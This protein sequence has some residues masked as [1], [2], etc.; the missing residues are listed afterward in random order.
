L[1]FGSVIALYAQEDDIRCRWVTTKLDTFQLD[2]LSILPASL[3]IK[4][5]A[6]SNLT[7]NYDLNTGQV[8][9]I[10]EASVDSIEICYRVLPFDLAKR[11]YHRDPLRYDSLERYSDELYRFPTPFVRPREEIFKLEGL[12][13]SG[14]L[15]RGISAGNNQSAFVNSSLNLQIE[16]QLSDEISILANIS[17]QDVPFQPEG[18]TLQLQE[19]DRVFVQ[20]SHRL[21]S[22]TVGDVVLKHKENYFLKYYKNVQGG[23]LDAKY[24][25]GEKSKANTSVGFAVAK[26]KFASISV[27]PLEGVQGPYRL[28]GPNGERFIIILANSEKVYIDGKLMTRG[29]NY[30]YVIDYN[31]AEIIFNTNIQITQFTRIRIDFEY[32]EQN[33]TRTI[34]TGSHY[35][36]FK[37]LD[38]FFNI[39]RASDNPRNPII[40]LSD[41]DRLLLS[42]A[43][44]GL[45]LV[46]GVDSVGFRSDAVLYE[47][48]DTLTVEGVLYENIWVYSTNP[49]LAIYQVSFTEVR[50]NQGDYVR[51]NN[52]ING[53]VYAWQ[54][55]INGVS[56]GNF[57]ARRIVPTPTQQQLMTAGI[58]YNLSESDR[59]YLE[60]GIS[61]QDNNRF[62]DLSNADN[63]GQAFKV[64]YLNE[65]KALPFGKEL[66]WSSHLS[67]EHNTRFFRPIDRF[68]SIEFNRDWSIQ[69]DTNR[70]ADNIL[71]LEGGL[72]KNQ[73]NFAQY[74]FTYRKR[75][76]EADGWQQDLHLKKELGKFILSY[77]MF[78]LR[79]VQDSI[80]SDWKRF[81]AD[82]GYRIGG[83]QVGY[84]FMQD[85]NQVL[86]P[87]LDSVIQT[88][89]NFDQHQLYF[90]T[91]DT[92]KVKLSMDFSLRE[93]NQP[94]EGRLVRSLYSQ[95]A[96]LRLEARPNAN[97]QIALTMTYR[98]LENTLDSIPKNN[99]NNLMGRLDWNANFWEKHVRSELSF[100]TLT[101]RE[102]Q[103]EFVFLQVQT[104][105]GTH[106]WR[107]DNQDGVQDLEEF[108]LAINPDERQY[109]KVFVPTDKYIEA[110]INNFSYR[111]NWQSPRNWQTKKGWKGF[112]GKFSQI[113]SWTINKRFTD[114]S[115]LSR[116]IPFRGLQD[117]DVLSTR[118]VMRTTLFFD[119]SNPAFGWEGNFL[120]NR[121]KQLLSN[122]FEERLQ[123]EY[124]F[125]VRGNLSKSINL[126][127]TPEIEFLRN[128]SNVLLNR[129]Y[130]VEGYSF[131]PEIAFQPSPSF[132]LTGSYQLTKRTGTS[133]DIAPE[134]ATL[135][136]LKL[137][138][139]V[140]QVGKRNILL[141]VRWVQIQYN[142]ET[143]TPLSYE[144]LEALNPG[145]N[146]TWT[147]NWQQRLA[148]GL[149]L[150]LNY[151]GRKP[152]NTPTIHV[153]RIQ[154]TALF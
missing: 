113:L 11:R 153:G 33:Y 151:N 101:G 48:R 38:F 152:P 61:S 126:S 144:M 18:N 16:G 13:K 59:V 108:Y 117:T 72:R 87:Q 47:Q 21:G 138:M 66:F 28:T 120:Q 121:Q 64:G 148:N 109:I 25:I 130:Q 15:T 88:A 84:R 42:N 124:G 85:K 102:L 36:N 103:R 91:S 149:Q 75:G 5:P 96:N 78:L 55:P 39:H 81:G 145:R 6:Q 40:R 125:L 37:K 52:T 50:A 62:S 154:L 137:E 29:F 69:T 98:R 83:S 128:E 19:F 4:T 82:I 115:V 150:N 90:Q 53:Q 2:T 49:N 26:G 76:E 67:F 123:R 12:Q 127:F 34:F 94:R 68:R 70:I 14:N 146:F 134:E 141:D 46:N 111:L 43:G 131:Q 79:N 133:A 74:R 77:D 104:G 110:F 122:G 100:A 106:T 147:F 45:G 23:I 30:D 136:Q 112:L 99:E 139:R 41:E 93:D 10:G 8:I 119:R 3:Q 132:R 1:W 107:D 97:Q 118:E 31:L 58:A 44:D 129:N 92:N 89:M 32:S 20:L 114:E 71:N 22:M 80:R 60:G 140:S 54:A 143:N 9:L 7:L 17:D 27:P 63:Q 56:Q 95:N 135:N 73:L 35:Q 51:L 142:G 57:I 86:V 116:L 105:V 65:G 24:T